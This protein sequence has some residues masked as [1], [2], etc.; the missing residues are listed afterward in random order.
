M[1]YTLAVLD[2]DGDPVFSI[3]IP[4]PR[5]AFREWRWRRYLRHHP[6]QDVPLPPDPQLAYQLLWGAIADHAA[7]V[8]QRF[9][10][11]IPEYS[12]VKGLTEQ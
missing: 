5:R 8:Y 10:R 1:T 4:N 7:L 11:D 6:R 2:D 3:A 9:Y 12:W